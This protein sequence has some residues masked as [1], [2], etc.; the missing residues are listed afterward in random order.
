MK[1]QEGLENEKSESTLT[2]IVI[3]RKE[4]FLSSSSET[5]QNSGISNHFS[6]ISHRQ[7]HWN[8]P[9]ER[10]G[11]CNTNKACESFFKSLHHT[12]LHNK[13][14]LLRIIDHPE[15]QEAVIL[16]GYELSQQKMMNPLRVDR[17]PEDVQISF[18]I[19]LDPDFSKFL[20][21]SIA[22]K[23]HNFYNNYLIKC[24][25]PRIR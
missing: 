16:T 5:R 13:S 7:P 24:L 25:V 8:R 11:L 1:H 15:L 18:A 14:N 23:S 10:M 3:R 17:I 12:F 2:H 19:V 20:Q 22:I 6:A 4:T 21:K 9:G